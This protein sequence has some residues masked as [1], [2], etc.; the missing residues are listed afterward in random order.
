M[1]CKGQLLCFDL[2]SG[3]WVAVGG[4]LPLEHDV[5]CQH[6]YSPYPWPYVGDDCEESIECGESCNKS[7]T[8]TKDKPEKKLPCTCTEEQY[9]IGWQTG[10]GFSATCPYHQQWVKDRRKAQGYE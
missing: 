10:E 1:V 4:Q 9:Q 3:R 6:S 7:D 2:Q 5:N 8:C